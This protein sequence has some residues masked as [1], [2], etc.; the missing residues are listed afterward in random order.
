VA[1]PASDIQQ[2]ILMAARERFLT[3]GVDGASLRQI[4]K[5][6]GTNIGM[7][8]YYYETKDE[9]FL[10][11][12]QDVYSKLLS[13]L[14]RILRTATSA[15]LQFAGIYQR[16]SQLSPE[17]YAV[18]RLLLREALVSSHRLT[19]V[20]QLFL[21]GHIPLLLDSISSGV[22]A[23]K[24]RDDT[25]PVLL[26]AASLILGIM[27]QLMRR[28]VQQAHPALDALLPTPDEIA[29]VMSDLLFRGIARQP[30]A[31]AAQ[32]TKPHE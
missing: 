9:L 30:H 21:H 3:E 18:I 19:E 20:G 25:P 27:P 28:M 4:A 11:I 5:D 8:Y 10:A 14:E 32:E 23:Q 24:L 29:H 22:Q 26:M 6:A 7:V 16:F 13:D 1:R 31:P 2:R 15:E 17:E 12:I